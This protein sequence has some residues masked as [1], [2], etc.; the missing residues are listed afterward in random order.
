MTVTLAAYGYNNLSGSARTVNKIGLTDFDQ[1]VFNLTFPGSTVYVYV[2]QSA[3]G[4]EAVKQLAVTGG[5]NKSVAL[6]V[7]D[8]SGEFYV[9]INLLAASGTVTVNVNKVELK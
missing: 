1:I 7:S 6:D 5:T 2:T 3:T 8:L 4:Y 9:G